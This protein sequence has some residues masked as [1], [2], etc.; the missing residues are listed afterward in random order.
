MNRKLI[1]ITKDI[2]HR[3]KGDSVMAFSSQLSYGIITAFFPFLIFLLTAAPYMNIDESSVLQSLRVLVP[4]DTF[5]LIKRVVNETLSTKRPHL[6]IFSLIFAVSSSISGVKAVI[7]GLNKANGEHETRP[8]YNVVIITIIGAV[9]LIFIITLSFV[10]LVVGE[11]LGDYLQNFYKISDMV[12]LLWDSLRFFLSILILFVL[13]AASYYYFPNRQSSWKEV[14]PG[15]LISTLGW[16]ITSGG[17]AFYINKF[18]DYTK[19]YGSVD[20]VF[21]L[22]GWIYLSSVIIIVGGEINASLICNKTQ[23]GVSQ[24]EERN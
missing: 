20:A 6:L 23:N 1:V 7:D 14:M 10:M 4:E 3:F 16:V 17:F 2:I 9:A 24:E 22:M 12:M 18:S 5:S 8:L 13:F 19:F 11:A 21:M 15:A